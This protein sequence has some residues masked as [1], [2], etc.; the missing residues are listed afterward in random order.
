MWYNY[1]NGKGVVI[2]QD[3]L[4]VYVVVTVITFLLTVLIIN[5]VFRDIRNMVDDEPV[6]INILWYILL[7]LVIFLSS[8]IP[9]YGQIQ[10]LIMYV[11][12]K[13]LMKYTKQ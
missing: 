1:I 11:G 3:I 13:Q 7:Y 12:M 6:K 8:L 9:V 2:L 10:L 5:K 4:L